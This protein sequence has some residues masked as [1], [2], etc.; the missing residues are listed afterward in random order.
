MIN[1]TMPRPDHCQPLHAATHRAHP[2][3]DLLPTRAV[4][5]RTLEIK[6]SLEAFYAHGNTLKS[7]PAAC[8]FVAEVHS[9]TGKR[10]IWEG[11]E[12]LAAAFLMPKVGRGWWWRRRGGGGASPMLPDV[13]HRRLVCILLARR[14]C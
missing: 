11:Q 14:R 1:P 5:P 13:H 9:L 12:C 8:D 3:N 2:Q 4:Y 7:T 6:D 10:I